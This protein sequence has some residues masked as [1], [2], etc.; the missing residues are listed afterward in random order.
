MAIKIKEVL[1]EAYNSV[2]QVKRYYTPLRRAYKIIQDEL[3][4][5]Q[6]NKE[7]ML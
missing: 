7:I 3:K 1:I 5:E 4:D 2:S 6:I